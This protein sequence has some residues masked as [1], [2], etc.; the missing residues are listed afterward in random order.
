MNQLEKAI[1]TLE[2]LDYHHVVGEILAKNDVSYF[3]NWSKGT[4]ILAIMG[5]MGSGKSTVASIFKRY[6]DAQVFSFGQAVKVYAHKYAKYQPK[7]N[8]KPRRLYQIFGE[9]CKEVDTDIWIKLLASELQLALNVAD[10]PVLAVIDDLRFPNERLW[11]YENGIE[12]I[13]IVTTD[14]NREKRMEDRGD[15]FT[16][17]QL[18]H[19]SE[20]WVD[21]LAEDYLIVN[22][23][24]LEDLEKEILFKYS[25]LRNNKRG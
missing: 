5:K 17:E 2:K 25:W 8:E 11:A 23:G 13:Q 24:T 1:E 10:K 4:R 15:L 7:P 20:K 12:V 21:I 18:K 3:L 22:N 6:F 14:L 16:T 9:K 19:I